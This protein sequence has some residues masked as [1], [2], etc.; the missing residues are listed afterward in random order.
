MFT[1]LETGVGLMDGF[2]SPISHPAFLSQTMG[3]GCWAIGGHGWGDPVSDREAI[4]A[5]QCAYGEGIVFFDTAD[6]YGLGRSERLLFRALGAKRHEVSIATKGGVRWNENNQVWT[7]SSPDYLRIAIERSLKR[8]ELEQIPLYYIHKSDGITPVESSMEAMVSMKEAGKIKYIG[9][10]NFNCDDV[11]KM[12]TVGSIDFIQLRLNLFER[13]E[14]EAMQDLCLRFGI[15][16]VAWGVLADG[17]LTGKFSSDTRFAANDHR[18]RMTMFS[19]DSFLK[20]LNRVDALKKFAQMIQK[21]LSQIALR[22][23][24]DHSELNYPLFGA[25]NCEQ[26]LENQGAADW[27]FTPDE[28]RQIDQI[29]FHD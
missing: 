13:S 10:S 18:S 22:W 9:V 16:I 29:I 24:L 6:V 11:L 4:R 5:I 26:V 19:K 20:N 7:D 15:K 14:F 3:M 1:G 2:E 28:L 23:V 12:L 8:L 25:K 21:P 27:T 17:L